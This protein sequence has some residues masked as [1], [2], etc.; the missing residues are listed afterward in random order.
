[1]RNLLSQLLER[2]KINVSIELQNIGEKKSKLNINRPLAK[3][4]YEELQTLATELGAPQ[5][6][7]FRLIMQMSDVYGQEENTEETEQDW[8]IIKQAL[9]EALQ[10]CNDFRVKEG[11][12]LAGNLAAYIG[13]IR[14]LLGQIDAY[15]PQRMENIRRRI[16]THIAD[17][18]AD[19]HFDKKT[20]LSKK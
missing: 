20:A 8:Q 1:M 9:Q 4:Y 16:T 17:V 12:E 13:K 5:Q 11:K 10:A 3:V 18:V 7:I 2:G 19:E 14:A 6:E 15:D